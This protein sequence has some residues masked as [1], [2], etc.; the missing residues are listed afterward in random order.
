MVRKTIESGFV[1]K[2]GYIRRRAT[3]LE[4]SAPKFFDDIKY[5]FP[6]HE[7]TVATGKQGTFF[8]IDGNVCGYGFAVST[9][10]N[11]KSIS[12][13]EVEFLMFDEFLVD[14][15]QDQRYLKGEVLM[16]LDLYNTVV[17]MRDKPCFFIGN[18]I[19]DVNP[20]F[21]FW[22]LQTPINKKR[23]ICKNDILVQLVES[24]AYIQAF[25]ETR[26]GRLI[27]GTE[28]GEYAVMNKPLRDTDDFVCKT[29]V[30]AVYNFTLRLNERD[31]GVYYSSKMNMYYVSKSVDPSFKIIFTTEKL[32]HGE[33]VTLLRGTN[34]SV[35]FKRFM[36]YF[37]TSMFGVSDIETKMILIRSL[38]R[39]V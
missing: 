20:Y 7:F 38:G 13:P 14:E 22:G 8:Y 31:V 25:Y 26:F 3:E 21:S 12:Y 39:F 36:K 5:Q 16:F 10:K 15:D 17:R 33:G 23:I 28:Y 37:S 32:L 18:R 6:D 29:P 9:A 2:F 19:S 24:E 35:L 34:G 30:D 4:K 11:D 27:K 1:W